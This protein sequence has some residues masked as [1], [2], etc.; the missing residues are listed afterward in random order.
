VRSTLDQ[1]PPLAVE[2]AAYELVIDA[3][4]QSL[5][6]GASVLVVRIS[7]DADEILVEASDGAA[8]EPQVRTRLADR[9]G[10]VGGA[11]SAGVS[12]QGGYLRAVLPCA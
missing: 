1:R 3:L 2:T 7:R 10:A 6:R 9:I 11:L 5:T 4:G 8:D 12:A